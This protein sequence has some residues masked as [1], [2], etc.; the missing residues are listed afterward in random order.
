MAYGRNDSR[1]GWSENRS[2][3]DEDR[4]NER[5]DEGRGGRGF[6]ERA[7]DE[8]ASWFGDDDAERRRRQDQ[9]R[10]RDDYRGSRATGERSSY[11]SDARYRDEGYR[12]P[13][14]GRFPGRNDGLGYGDRF[15][16]DRA[17]ENDRNDRGYGQRD[18]GQREQGRR[19]YG[20]SSFGTMAAGGAGG[21]YDRQ[22]S[23]WR[24]QQIDALDRD[25]HD[26]RRENEGRFENE[27]T[28]W[29][30]TRQG[31]RE[32]V[33]SI[34]E[35]MTVVG[36]DGAHVGTIDKVRGDQLILTKS[37]SSD[38]HHHRVPCSMIDRVE[39]DQVWLDQPAETAL[40]RLDIEAKRGAAYDRDRAL[41]ADQRDEQRDDGPHLLNRSFTGTY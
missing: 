6:F 24:R 8:V 34:K 15:G 22:Y 26:Y 1:S 29:R 2:R 13:Y 39:N 30:Q 21:L 10:E 41:G 37:D 3:F 36:N 28:S 40:Q 17:Y 38:G 4:Y 5:T 16:Y 7:G 11:D 32:L 19:D 33:K 20:Q 31:K 35:H 9:A 18:Y 14:T 25:Y 12:R 23:D 27:F